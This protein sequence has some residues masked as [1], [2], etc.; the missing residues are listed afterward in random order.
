MIKVFIQ[1]KAGS[2]LR[3]QVH[4]KTLQ[5]LGTA[6]LSAVHPW[7]YGFIINTRAVDGDC[8]D[9]FIVTRTP[10]TAGRFVNCQPAGL[11]EMWEENQPDHKILALLLNEQITFNR[12]DRDVLAKFISTLFLS[13]P[14]TKIRIGR[15]LPASAALALIY[16][17][18]F[19]HYSA[20]LMKK[21]S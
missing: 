3:L 11:L 14:E 20:F 2:N 7:A 12:E 13:Y 9:C 18:Q 21:P 15:L 1:S 4:K 19:I 8:L 5:V 16:K 17:S 10:L 6:A